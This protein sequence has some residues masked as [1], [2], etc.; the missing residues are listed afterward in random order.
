MANMMP[1]KRL[2]EFKEQI[3]KAADGDE[4]AIKCL[5][6]T[7]ENCA[8]AMPTSTLID[9]CKRLAACIESENLSN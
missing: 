9:V 4:F 6:M 1:S 5:R 2:P 7:L 3:M 8:A